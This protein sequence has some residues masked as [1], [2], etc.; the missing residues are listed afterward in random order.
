MEIQP[1]KSKA[2]Y[3][4]LIHECLRV[5]SRFTHANQAHLL[6]LSGDCRYPNRI[7]SWRGAA[8]P[9]TAS[10][11]ATPLRLDNAWWLRSLRA[12]SA[13]NRLFKVDEVADL[14]DDVSA[15]RQ[16]LLANGVRALI[17]LPVFD[18]KRLVGNVRL[19]N[20][21][22]AREF[23]GPESDLLQ[24]AAQ[25]VMQV[26]CVS[27]DLSELKRQRAY[28][29]YQNSHDQHTDLPNRVLFHERIQ[30]VLKNCGRLFAVILVDFDDHHLIYKRF[31]PETGKSL[32]HAAVDL[33]RN[34]LRANDMVARLDD[35]QFGILIEDLQESM[36]AENVA[37]RILSRLNEPFTI[38]GKKVKMS[39]SIGI[40]MRNGHK[41]TPE[42]ILH[43]AGIALIEARQSGRNHYRL[44]DLSMR[45][46]LIASMELES[47]L[48]NSLDHQHLVLHY[49]P[50][51]ELL[52][53]RL[54]GF[55]ALVRWMHPQR[56]LIW[57]SEFIH[58]SEQTG[59]IVPLGAWVLREACR[60]MR[61]W[62]DRYPLVPPLTI[63]V[64]ISPRQLEEPDFSCQVASVLEET[65]LPPTSLRLEL[66][67]STIVQRTPTAVAALE[68][69]RRMGV[70]LYIDDFGTGY[71]S[72][73]YLDSLPIDAI[74]IDRTFVN[75]LGRARSSAGVV[76]AIINLARELGIE[77]VAEGVETSEQHDVLKRLR[78]GFM[79]GFY[80]SEPLDPTRVDNFIRAIH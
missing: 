30:G 58:L 51:T 71:S 27:H 67:E 2:D 17:L 48:R 45:E 7:Y 52:T 80:I 53:G 36:Y 11:S 62:Q 21:L 26:L 15:D 64:N 42:L 73:G 46:K 34:N 59:L 40:T 79:Q 61:V 8:G 54:I 43:E 25:L 69:L 16:H 75:N 78:C 10:Q 13:E 3:E 22:P 47:D 72:L 32:L 9:N 24:M 50:I 5:M 41:L 18:G 33:L 19:E 29:V 4:A 57:P 76:Q 38:D 20:P 12:C 37:Q 6:F 44:F 55:E 65:N 14:P 28:L 68:S 70:Q 74:K 60:Q 35:S 77:V 63:S 39:A 66:T 31:G 49:Q 1:G 56:G 23:T